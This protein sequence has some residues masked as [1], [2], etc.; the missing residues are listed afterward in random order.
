ML[1]VG[2]GDEA[3]MVEDVCGPDLHI[4]VDSA[5]TCCSGCGE[6][7]HL[8]SLLQQ[9]PVA[10]G[11][12]R[13]IIML[14]SDRVHVLIDDQAFVQVGFGAV[15]EDVV[16]DSRVA[17]HQPSGSLQSILPCELRIDEHQV[18]LQMVR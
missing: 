18:A 4:A 11:S 1:R 8:I 10:F 2:L 12:H 6:H 13:T 16:H 17:A 7:T 14:D 9:Q 5:M 15:R 3:D